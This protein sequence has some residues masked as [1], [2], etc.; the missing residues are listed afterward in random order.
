MNADA[1]YLRAMGILDKDVADESG[2][3]KP[4][5]AMKAWLKG[6][7]N[8]QASFEATSNTIQ[9]AMNITANLGKK[10]RE[11]FFRKL[12]RDIQVLRDENQR[13]M[14]DGIQPNR[15]LKARMSNEPGAEIEF[16]QCNDETRVFLNTL[17]LLPEPLWRSVYEAY[18]NPNEGK[19]S[20]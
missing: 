20:S 1:A 7:A 10:D 15:E 3:I 9:E 5:A 16:L 11:E 4:N 14:G 17:A 13:L 2:K 8:A 18:Q 19:C 6:H 12:Q